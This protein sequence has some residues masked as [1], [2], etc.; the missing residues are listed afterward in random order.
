MQSLNKEEVNYFNETYQSPEK[1]YD[2]YIL[3]LEKGYSLLKNEGSL[4][5]ILPHKFF[6]GET[7]SKIRHFLYKN[8]AVKEIVDFT[9]N[10]IFEG[11]T[12]YT[13]LLFINKSENKKFLYKKFALGENF[14][15]LQNI[16]FDSKNIDVLEAN[17]WNF[18]DNLT[19]EIINKIKSKKDKFEDITSKIFKGSSTGND[20]IFLFDL[21][22]DKGEVFTVFS[23]KLNHNLDLEQGLLVP[24]V[25]GEDI[26]RYK[27][28]RAK[29]LL[30]FPYEPN[31]EGVSLI[32]I[33]RLK[34]SYP[35][36]YKYLIEVKQDLLKRKVKLDDS[37]F[38]KYSAARS[39]GEYKQSKIMIPDML[40]RIRI[41]YDKDGVYFHGPAIHSVVFKE[42]FKKYDP[43]FYLGILNSKI[44]WFFISNT[45]TALSGDAY[46]LTP[47]FLNSFCF[48]ET[49][50]IKKEQVS[51]ITDHAKEI[52]LLEEQF[53]K[54]SE[55]S[56]KWLKLRSEI[57]KI[58][59][60]I[61]DEVY[62][63]YDLTTEE[64]KIVEDS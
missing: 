50:R 12:T 58:D 11:A 31:E 29:K 34:I 56:E 45:S 55:N 3:F 1:N 44:F 53:A 61:N 2:I 54:L 23:E 43:L 9:T 28:I 40:V 15:N 33:D 17:P 39:L 20:E 64:I 10:Q 32:K 62:K 4:G 30:L 35:L 37:N 52:I 51:I 16:S 47:E 7:G 38:Y 13:C 46:R 49:S 59:H 48:P 19:Q 57:E 27:K 42:E 5:Y 41:G 26:K 22:E 18:S 14:K 60:K 36:I 6:Q 8:R 24:F 63:L 21:V 25:F